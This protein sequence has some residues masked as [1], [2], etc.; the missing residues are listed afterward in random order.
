MSIF[1]CDF[2]SEPN[3]VWGYPAQNFVAYAVAG[4]VGQSV[5]NWA[6]C[7][8]CHGLI[9]SGDRCGLLE[10]SLHLLLEKHPDMRSDEAGVREQLGVIHRMFFTYQT[11]AP[12][13]TFTHK[14]AVQF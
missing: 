14:M 4:V 1:I 11:G 8:V 6:A 12:L 10:R 2:C 5:G 9:E 3:V 13:C 7:T